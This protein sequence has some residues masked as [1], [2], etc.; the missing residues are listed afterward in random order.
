MNVKMFVV[1]FDNFVIVFRKDKELPSSSLAPHEANNMAIHNAVYGIHDT[2]MILSAQSHSNN[3]T[4]MAEHNSD[5]KPVDGEGDYE[6]VSSCEDQDGGLYYEL[7]ENV[8]ELD[9][10]SME[11]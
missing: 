8:E 3:S 6:I 10:S 7:E 2:D 11:T 5:A 9:C 4:A 1:I